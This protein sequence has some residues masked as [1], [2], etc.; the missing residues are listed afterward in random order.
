LW[1]NVF[2]QNTALYTILTISLG[3][4]FL[5]GSILAI[6]LT[7][8][9]MVLMYLSTSGTCSFLNVTLRFMPISANSFLRHSNLPSANILHTLNPLAQYA[10]TICYIDVIIVLFPLSHIN[11]AVL[12]C[13][14]LDVVI[15]NGI[16]LIAIMSIASITSPY[17]SSISSSTL[18]H[19][20]L[21]C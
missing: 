16:L 8:S 3:G 9:L 21:T 1:G 15:I 20:I 17:F 2:S 10:L 14:F 19:V 5:N 6:A 13:I 18:V 7:L 4:Y 11:S 12:K